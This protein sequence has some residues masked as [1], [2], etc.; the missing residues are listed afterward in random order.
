MGSRATAPGASWPAEWEEEHWVLRSYR[1]PLHWSPRDTIL[2]LW[3][4]MRGFTLEYAT[5]RAEVCM[6]QSVC[7]IKVCGMPVKYCGLSWSEGQGF[8]CRNYKVR[9]LSVLQK[10]SVCLVLLKTLAEMCKKA[11]L[12]DSV[13]FCI[14]SSWFVVVK[15]MLIFFHFPFVLWSF[16]RTLMK[17]WNSFLWLITFLGKGRGGRQF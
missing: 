8:A 2:L 15:L 13:V 11:V 10:S 1:F 14:L 16:I 9:F 6:G 12:V 17:N 4:H 7:Y 3:M 5:G